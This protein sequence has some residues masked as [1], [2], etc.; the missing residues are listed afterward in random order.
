MKRVILLLQFILVTTILILS[1]GC[2]ST[3][4]QQNQRWSTSNAFAPHGQETNPLSQQSRQI[5]LL[6][7]R[8]GPYA[9]YAN[10]IRNGFFT[11]YYDQK[12]QTGYAPTIIVIDTQNKNIQTVV[13][14][15][16]AQGADFIVG[17]LEKPNVLTLAE[18]H[19]SHVPI[20][21]LNTTPNSTRMNNTSLYEFG[22]S[23]TQEAEQAAEKAWQDHHRHVIILAPN[24]AQGQRIANA[25]STQWKTLGGTIVGQQFYGNIAS[26]SKSIRAVLQI[27][28]AYQNAHD[29]KNMFHEDMRFIPQRRH[30][31]DSIFLIATPDMGRQIQPLLRFYFVDNIPI[32]T[33]SQIYTGIPNADRDR[34][35][36]GILFCDMPW[37]LAPNLQ[38]S[39]VRSVQQHIQTLWPDT[40]RRLAKFYAMG[41]DAFNLTLQLNKM[42][43]Q[44]RV[45]VSA[46]TGTL[47]LTPKRTLD[48]QLVW[49]QFKN[50]E[51]Q[52]VR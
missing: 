38:P 2:S 32:Y 15:A 27:D 43:S 35:L 39:S 46:A 21:A 19:Q 31:F 24:N 34:D 17:P 18:S 41:V 14:T 9:S 47:Y 51:P 16:V 40:A 37:I 11:A 44:P 12:N 26:L 48:R 45:G 22:L 28:S 23:P 5:A 42:Q 8:S 25:F 33:T 52:L 4:A 50:G 36:D 6:L 20:L 29:L 7:P 10:A 30:D 49:A 1:N 13:Q 3:S